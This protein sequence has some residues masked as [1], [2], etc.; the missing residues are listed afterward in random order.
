MAS[1]RRSPTPDVQAVPDR[2]QQRGWSVPEIA[3]QVK[4]IARFQ[5]L[6]ERR[7]AGKFTQ[8]LQSIC[9]SAVV[10]S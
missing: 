2:L 9:L 3:M 5:R 4:L 6:A 7:L 10:C 1:A 8:R